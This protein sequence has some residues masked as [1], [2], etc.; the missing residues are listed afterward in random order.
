MKKKSGCLAPVQEICRLAAERAEDIYSARG[1]CCSEAVILVINQ[2]F[3]GGL[4]PEIAVRLGSAFCHGMGGAGCAC[5][6][7]AGAQ[8]ILGLFLSPRQPG[9][10]RKKAFEKTV[11]REMHDLFKERFRATCC[12]VL[13][14]RRK[15][16]R[17]HAASCAALTAGGAAIAA[18]LLLRARPDL[19]GRADLKFLRTREIKQQKG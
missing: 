15:E 4:A 3:D 14:R 1:L 8:V 11:S 19:H 5:G 7:L 12:R 17:E 18:E 2:A 6:A 9:G 13:I 10:M 16:E